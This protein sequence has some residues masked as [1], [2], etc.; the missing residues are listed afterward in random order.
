V[1]PCDVAAVPLL[2]TIRCII[3]VQAP[4]LGFICFLIR[5]VCCCVLVMD[6]AELRLE[7]IRKGAAVVVV[8][9]TWMLVRL[10]IRSQPSITYGPMSAREE[11]C[12]TT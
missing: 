10:R 6:P 12:Q 1:N 2:G 9:C 5:F 7:M 8:L 3:S 11:Q 4:L